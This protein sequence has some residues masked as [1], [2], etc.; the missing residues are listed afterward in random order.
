ML[1]EKGSLKDEIFRL[2]GLVFPKNSKKYVV[3]EEKAL[4]EF[5]TL[6]RL[7]REKRYFEASEKA[8]QLKYE[9][10]K[11]YDTN[12]KEHFFLLRE[13]SPARGWGHEPGAA[14]WY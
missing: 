10:V 11:Y 4:A 14:W 7:I 6:A 8:V 3:P 9:L 12:T 1:Q 2:K 5:R 13:S